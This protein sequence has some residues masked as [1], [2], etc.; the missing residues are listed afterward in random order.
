MTI[1]KEGFNRE[2]EAQRAR[3]RAGSQIS[4]KVF[5]TGPLSAVKGKTPPTV[6][7]GY[8]KLSTRCSVKHILTADGLVDRLGEGMRASLILDQTPFYAEAGGQVG[9][10][11]VIRSDH[12]TF[13][14]D[15]GTRSDGGY[16]LHSG[17]LTE[18][19]L[20][21]GDPATAEVDEA[22]RRAIQGNHT[23]THLLH[24]HLRKVLGAHVEQKGS[25]VEPDRLRFDFHHTAALKPGEIA[26]VQA[27]VNADIRADDP[28]ETAE[29]DLDEARAL[30]A[31]ALFGE[32]YG[33]R[34]RV[35]SVDSARDER[36]VELCGG[37]H[38][39]R[40]GEIGGFRI[41]SEES[42]AAGTRRIEAATG[43]GLD[44]ILD[45]KLKILAELSEALKVSDQDLTRTVKSLQD[46]LK[47]A[48]KEIRK[49]Q[50]SE[51][52]GQVDR[53]RDEG[54]S[55]AGGLRLFSGRLEGLPVDEARRMCDGLRGSADGKA[56]VVLLSVDGERVHIVA[57][58][59]KPFIEG[60]VK[61]GDVCRE[62]GRE[63]GG[64]GGG[65]PGMAQGQGK[66]PGRAEEVLEAAVA[67]IREAIGEA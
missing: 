10:H 26:A 56:G 62:L 53:I 64:G 63:L 48:R 67:R 2:M 36:S 21:K 1:D 25:L 38:V 46:Q 22:K 41:V 57:A 18:G 52:A 29:H 31:M 42:I 33:D 6:F 49:I 30:G 17:L 37:T 61:A 24:Y 54:L 40:T 14:V 16:Y 39:G 11:G 19:G 55:L 47:E 44:E 5:D 35:V 65:K 43:P 9:D 32:K 60:G 8:D 59:D 50:A 13:V 23:A 12:F 3:A 15:G 51:A 45:R 7:V 34:V 66:D 58:F 28:V 4:D 27:G 20:A